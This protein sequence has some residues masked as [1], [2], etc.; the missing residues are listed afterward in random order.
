M[1]ATAATDFSAELDADLET[2]LSEGSLFLDGKGRVHETLKRIATRLD[3]L[4]IDYAVIGGMALFYHGYRRFTEDVDL[5]VTKE[6]RRRI[7]EALRGRGYLPPFEMSKHLRDTHTKVKIEFIT[8]GDYP[9]DGKP[10]PVVFPTPSS[11]SEKRGDLQVVSLP[12]LIELKLA[13]GISAAGRMRDLAD[14]QELIRYLKLDRTLA[15][16]LDPYVR[17]KFLELWDGYHSVPD[18]EREIR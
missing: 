1:S 3:E 9:G 11:V 6:D 8:S 13:S 10:K 7:H 16:A 5:L 15:E 17:A 14:V 4:K 2:A 18:D 12:R